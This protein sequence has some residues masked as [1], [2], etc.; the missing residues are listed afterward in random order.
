MEDVLLRIT[1]RGEGV[2]KEKGSRFLSFAY[3]VT[4][5][6]E[7]ESHLGQL[8]KKFYDARH[9]CL[10][11]RLGA[12][13]Q[14][15]FSADD[16]EPGN[17]AGPPILA[18][19]RSQGLTDTLV[20]VVRYFGGTKLGIRGLIEAY[21]DAADRALAQ[22][23][24]VPIIPTVEFVIDYAYTQTSE[25]QKALHPFPVKILDSTY[26]ASCSQVLSIEAKE[27]SQ[28]HQILLRIPIKIHSISTVDL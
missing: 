17:S 5:V 10:A 4:Q 1:S 16:R 2:L 3:P 6:S 26:D 9:H 14:T 13:G 8:K 24:R 23:E 28:L 21:R 20:V 19:I 27:F 22:S 7:V 15:S 12:Q 18:A 11:Y 25:V